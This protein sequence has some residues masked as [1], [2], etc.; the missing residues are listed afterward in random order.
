[1]KVQVSKVFAKFINAVSEEFGLQC[2]AEVVS[3]PSMQYQWYVGDTYDGE[4]GGDFDWTTGK[5]KVIKVL[6]P[7][8]FFANPTYLTTIRL[9]TEARRRGVSDAEG[10]KE[11][12]RDLVEI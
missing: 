5:F 2:E 8:E 12:I 11:M 1:M 6:Y 9:N 7:Y 3:M 10:L 4:R